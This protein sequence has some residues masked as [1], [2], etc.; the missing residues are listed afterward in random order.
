MQ[1]PINCFGDRLGSS[2]VEDGSRNAMLLDEGG[3]L[4]LDQGDEGG[5]Y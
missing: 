1:I 5:D 3:N 2:T 4:V